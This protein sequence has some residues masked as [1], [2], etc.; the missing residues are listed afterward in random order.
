[1]RTGAP[2]KISPRHAT[3]SGEIGE[4]HAIEGI[5]TEPNERDEDNQE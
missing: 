5:G 3:L 4:R 2:E 1:M